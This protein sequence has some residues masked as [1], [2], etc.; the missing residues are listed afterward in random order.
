MIIIDKTIV[1]EDLL[2]KQFVCNLTKCKGA[3]CVEGESGAPLEAEETTI[4]ENIYEHVKPYMEKEG[5]ETVERI[6]KW[7]IDSDGDF[8]TPLIGGQGRC[9]Y[10]FFDKN[11]IAKC[12]IEQANADGKVDF[13][14]PISCHL[15][16]VRIKKHKDY[17]A[18]NYDRWDVCSPAC[19]NGKEL[20]VPVYRFV[21]NALV[22]K[23]GAEWYAQL[24]GAALY[25]EESAK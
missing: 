10:V 18:V 1:S 6:G 9:A 5:I 4:L 2:D 14:K 19:A 21:K 12:A 16:P 13:K 11:K 24:E 8:V 15:Y 17:D 3:C 22:R 25:R 23:Y 20:G 7:H